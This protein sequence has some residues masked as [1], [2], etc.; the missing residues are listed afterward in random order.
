LFL[1]AIVVGLISRAVAP[2]HYNDT[3]PQDEPE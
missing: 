2:E 3:G 1:A